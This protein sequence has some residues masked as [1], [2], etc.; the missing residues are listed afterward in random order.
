MDIYEKYGLLWRGRKG[1]AAV[2]PEVS[3]NQEVKLETLPKINSFN[4]SVV[5]AREK[6]ETNLLFGVRK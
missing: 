3:E 4:D 1:E 2:I 5:E 6:V